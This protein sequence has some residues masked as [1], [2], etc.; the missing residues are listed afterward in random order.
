[1]KEICVE[2]KVLPKS[3]ILDVQGRAIVQTLQQNGKS[4]QDCRYGKCIRLLVKAVDEKSA[5]EKVKEM[6]EMVLYNPLTETY[7]MKVIS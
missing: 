1:M 2:V 5:E 3:E 6:A 7:E 4:I